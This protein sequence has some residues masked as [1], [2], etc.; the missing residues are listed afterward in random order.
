MTAERFLPDPFSP[1]PGARLYRSGDLVCQ[2]P[3]GSLEYLGRRDSQIK[4]RGHRIELGEIEYHLAT[5]PAV[6]EAAAVFVRRPPSAPSLAAFVVPRVLPPPSHERLLLRRLPFGPVIA[7]VNRSET[8]LLYREIFEERVYLRHGITLR[9]GDCIFDVGANIGLFSLFATWYAP[10]CR[11]FALEPALPVFAALEANARGFRGNVQPIACALANFDGVAELTF[12]PEMSG[13]SSLYGN[14]A[15]DEQVARAF[16][17]N[18]HPS[19]ALHEDELLAGRLRAQ[20]LPCKVARLSS[21]IDQLAIAEINLLK[22]DV[23]KSEMDV[24]AGIDDHHWVRIQQIVLEVHDRANRLD[25]LQM[26]LREKGYQVTVDQPPALQETGLYY[27]YAIRNSFPNR[28]S[29]RPPITTFVS[30]LAAL[31]RF[32][33]QSRVPEPMVPTRILQ[34]QTLP[35][36]QSGKLD[37]VALLEELHTPMPSRPTAASPFSTPLE[38]RLARIWQNVLGLDSI[39]AHDNFFEIGGDSIVSVQVVA[40]ARREGI[41]FTPRELFD[42]PT[43]SGLASIARMHARA[44]P[45]PVGAERLDLPLLP[46]QSWFF[47]QNLQHPDHY[48]QSVLLELSGRLDPG[49]LEQRLRNAVTAHQSLRLRFFREVAIWRQAI[50]P[51]AP[52]P[53]LSVVELPPGATDEESATVEAYRA[54]LESSLHLETGRIV[55]GLLFRRRETRPDWLLLA[56]HHLAMDIVSWSLLL[57][58]LASDGLPALEG[59]NSLRAVSQALSDIAL[60]PSTKAELQLWLDNLQ[61]DS[62]LPRDEH[63]SDDENTVATSRVATLTLSEK[64]TERLLSACHGKQSQMLEMILAALSMALARYTQAPA[65]TIELETHGR[66]DQYAG[67]ETGRVVGWLAARYPLRIAVDLDAP[68]ATTLGKVREVLSRIPNGGTGYGLLRYS[69]GQPELTTARSIEVSFT[70]FGQAARLLQDHSIFSRL[71]D[72]RFSRDSR[73]RRPHV[74]EISGGLTNS[75]LTIAWTFSE[76]LHRLSTIETLLSRCAETLQAWSVPECVDTIVALTPLQEGLVFHGLRAGPSAY[77]GLVG[78]TLRGVLNVPRLKEALDCVLTR[79]E[80]L[81][82]RVGFDAYGKPQ[83]VICRAVKTALCEEDWTDSIIDGMARRE[84]GRIEQERRRGFDLQQAPL[85]RFLLI[86]RAAGLHRLLCFFHHSIVDGWSLSILFK[87]IFAYYDGAKAPSLSQVV[88][89]LLSYAQLWKSRDLLPAGRYWRS[90]ASRMHS[91]TVRSGRAGRPDD[92]RQQATVCQPIPSSHEELVRTSRRSGLTLSTILHGAMGLV[93]HRRT[94]QQ[95]VVIGT[96]L[97]YRPA[98]LPNVEAMVGL[99]M[100]TLPF[101][102]RVDGKLCVVDWLRAIQDEHTI[103]REF[104]Y[105][106]LVDVQRW[107]HFPPDS[108]LFDTVLVVENYPIGANFSAREREPRIEDIRFVDPSHYPFTLTVETRPQLLLR[109]SYDPISFP[110]DTVWSELCGLLALLD[111]LPVYLSLPVHRWLGVLDE[112]DRRYRLEVNCQLVETAARQLEQARRRPV[113]H[114][115]E[116]QPTI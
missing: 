104:A 75:R 114:P 34:R 70:Y 88:P 65:V 113:S 22:I 80:A 11:V 57:D 83:L 84:E 101:V 42:H 71:L 9:D 31:L 4:I 100:N 15:E 90:V 109:A 47:A 67:V 51:E 85:H 7:H 93:L 112:S 32:Y 98:E 97:A 3:D 44:S 86:R 56:A 43:I 13:M 23:E 28:Q 8:D 62:P 36:T 12:Y 26:L 17:R 33:L 59:S 19:L 60:L 20:N 61:Q 37:R 55:R 110:F 77:V 48:T 58:D 25:A 76:R 72:F 54:E 108:S 87:E 89:S 35:K 27:V 69:L 103:L 45:E 39:A 91:S 49:L 29:L 115:D 73:Q 82:C 94:G 68:P 24:L 50:L 66:S 81:R 1:F 74:F 96:A 107:C 63:A 106:P 95:H 105:S 111:A 30:D 10:D 18:L 14:P 78:C 6:Q 40:R 41:F 2:H 53:L 52:H 21:V 64:E 46:T 5:H 79:H 38:Q 92:L 116:Q 102:M 99:L 16:L